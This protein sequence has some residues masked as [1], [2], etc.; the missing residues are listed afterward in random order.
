MYKRQAEARPGHY[1]SVSGENDDRIG[2]SARA[3]WNDDHGAIQL[4]RIDNRSDALRHGELFDWATRFN[5]AGSDYTWRDWTFAAES[6]WGSTAI[7]T[8]RGRF[9]DEIA[10]A[11]LLVSRRVMKFRVT[12]RGDQYKVGAKRENALTAAVL[13]EARPKMRAAIEGI[14]AEGEKRMAVELRYRF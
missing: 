5:V 9:S 1:T 10:A 8:S 12:V 14:N 6:G 3:K 11:Y 13:W 4:T 2:W 7:V